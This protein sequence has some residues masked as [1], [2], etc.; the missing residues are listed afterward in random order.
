V[1]V[2]TVH[3]FPEAAYVIERFDRQGLYCVVYEIVDDKLIV[4]V[5]KITHRS[6]VY[7]N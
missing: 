7:N 5:V 2:T 6:N 4:H 1:P 3:Y